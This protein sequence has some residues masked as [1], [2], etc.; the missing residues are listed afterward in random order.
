M[1]TILRKLLVLFLLLVFLGA[2]LL[3]LPGAA[4]AVEEM[5]DCLNAG[6]GV[7]FCLWRVYMCRI[8]THCGGDYPW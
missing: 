3:L 1:R 2:P 6:H 5:D 7:I 4:R 8:L